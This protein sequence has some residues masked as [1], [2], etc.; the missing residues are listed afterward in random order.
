MKSDIANIWLHFK[1]LA[2]LQILRKQYQLKF[3]QGLLLLLTEMSHDENVDTVFFLICHP[4]GSFYLLFFN[5][6]NYLKRQRIKQT[7]MPKRDLNDHLNS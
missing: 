7:K 1:D 6:R 4:I 3:R 2:Y 5:T